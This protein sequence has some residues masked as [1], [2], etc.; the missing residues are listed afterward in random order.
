MMKVIGYV[1]YNRKTNSYLHT[2]VSRYGEIVSGGATIDTATIYEDEDRVNYAKSLY[3]QKSKATPEQLEVYK[4]IR[5]IETLV[6]D[7]VNKK[8]DDK[9]ID[10]LP[11]P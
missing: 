7:H 9:D 3:L 11:T 1:I 5:T 6:V 2:T 4:V 8:S 10:T